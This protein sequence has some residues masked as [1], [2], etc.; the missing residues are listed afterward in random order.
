MF[1]R[2]FEER[3]SDICDGLLTDAEKKMMEDH[4]AACTACRQLLQEVQ[5]LI[6][7]GKGF[8]AE[9][10]PGSLEERI[11]RATLGENRRFSLKSLLHGNFGFFY[12]IPRFAMGLAL[13]VGFI[14]FSVWRLESNA[15]AG[16]TTTQIILSQVDAFTH[17]IYTQGLELY[18]T[19]NRFV[20]ELDY[21]RTSLTSQIE[22]S[23][24][25]ITGGKKKEPAK[26]GTDCLPGNKQ[27]VKEEKR[28]SMGHPGYWAG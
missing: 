6:Q 20:S 24:N 25:Q 8:P 4:T 3:I 2:D 15:P 5:R 10:A 9:P 7:I 13:V 17:G 22:Y 18:Y 23:W 1:C 19:K 27:P 21:F 11:I 28:Q 16:S 14:S 26:P 12:R